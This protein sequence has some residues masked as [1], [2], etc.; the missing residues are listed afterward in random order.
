MVSSTALLSSNRV[1]MLCHFCGLGQVLLC[2]EVD[3][4]T[5]EEVL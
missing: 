2:F 5:S 1:L 4:N 3:C